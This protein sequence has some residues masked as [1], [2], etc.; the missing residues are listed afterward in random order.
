MRKPARTCAIVALFVAFAAKVA[1][2][3]TAKVIVP[4]T[5]EANAAVVVAAAVVVVVAAY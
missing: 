5:V 2:L 3:A 1:A 4:L